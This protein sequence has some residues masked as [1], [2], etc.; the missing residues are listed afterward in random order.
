MAIYYLRRLSKPS[1]LCLQL[2]LHRAIFYHVLL[3]RRTCHRATMPPCHQF[4]LET[5]WRNGEKRLKISS[6][7]LGLKAQI[8]VGFFQHPRRQHKQCDVDKLKKQHGS[9]KKNYLTQ[10][11]CSVLSSSPKVTF[12]NAKVLKL[13]VLKAQHVQPQLKS[14]TIA[15]S[16]WPNAM[17]FI[18]STIGWLE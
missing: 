1:S 15:F 11:G 4:T 7:P 3:G 6:G 8:P 9:E 17:K 12:E 10:R 18:Q 5:E 13:I 16:N 2:F 14:E